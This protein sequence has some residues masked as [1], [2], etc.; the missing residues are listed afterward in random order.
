MMKAWNVLDLGREND[1]EDGHD[2][3]EDGEED[4][5]LSDMVIA[6]NER[7][8]DM[9]ASSNNLNIDISKLNSV[10]KV[11]SELSFE[12]IH[13]NNGKFPSQL[14]NNCDTEIS[15]SLFFPISMSNT[16]PKLDEMNGGIVAN[17]KIDSIN[18]GDSNP[19]TIN[20]I[21]S[22]SGSPVDTSPSYPF[23]HNRNLHA[24]LSSPDRRRAFSPSEA[25]KK[26]EARHVSAESN[27]DSFVAERRL[28]A[29]LVSNRVKMC[30]E[31]EQ[32]KRNLA[33]MALEERLR[34]AEKR[35]EDCIKII[36]DRAGNE[37]TKVSEVMFINNMNAEGIV[38]EL[39][40]KLIEVEARVLAAV[41]R[42]RDI[43]TGITVRQRKKNHRKVQ[44]MSELRLQLERLKMER[45]DKLQKRLE[46]VQ[47]R[48]Q[49]R[50]REMQRRSDAKDLP[51]SRGGSHN[52]SLK[53]HKESSTK[54]G[55]ALLKEESSCDSLIFKLNGLKDQLVNPLVSGGG[56][57]QRGSAVAVTTDSTTHKNVN[58][59]KSSD[60]SSSSSS[61]SCN[62]KTA[63]SR[64]SDQKVDKNKDMDK[65]MDKGAEKD[66]DKLSQKVSATHIPSISS[67]RSIQKSASN[68]QTNISNYTNIS[69]DKSSTNSKN[70][71]IPIPTPFSPRLKPTATISTVLSPT[72][73]YSSTPTS[74]PNMIK[75]IGFR[76]RIL[77]GM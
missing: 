57:V 69:N 32:T 70:S 76:S 45:W 38:D 26:Q 58:N 36:R 68:N 75:P 5:E 66:I 31:K 8:L 56:E 74:S 44:Q 49:A 10:Q 23:G 1:N 54:G 6:E 18:D 40:Q 16:T 73:S 22:R 67:S 43:L 42:R 17:N 51:H 53:D 20:V 33:E 77:S 3:D 47:T 61:S 29:M 71:N 59:T 2:N 37:N 27:R 65:N 19:F 28:K 14:K 72:A 39:R 7:G 30:N 41:E 34:D 46:D 60:S 9:E 25:K 13:E 4:R 64:T 21:R 11:E 15:Q 52:S 63:I 48:R 55:E 24:K 50:L 35:H 62:S 12:P